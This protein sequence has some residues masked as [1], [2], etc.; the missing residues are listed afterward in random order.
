MIQKIFAQLSIKKAILKIATFC[1]IATAAIGLISVGGANAAA[2]TGALTGDDLWG[3]TGIKSTTTDAIG[4]S[5]KDPRAIIA[6]VI[7]VVLGFLGIIAVLIV[8]TGGF[9][10]MTAGGNDDDVVEARQMMVAGAIGLVIVLASFGLASFAMNAL[11]TAVG[12]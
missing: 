6:A 8:V 12:L 10:Y 2:P 9:K 4:L 3:G 1:F 7:R 11:S 5:E